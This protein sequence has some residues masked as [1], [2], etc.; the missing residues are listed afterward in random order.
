MFLQVRC[1]ALGFHWLQVPLSGKRGEIDID[2]TP[3][4]DIIQRQLS[5]QVDGPGLAAKSP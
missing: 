2:N 3:H 4:F 5:H 1:A